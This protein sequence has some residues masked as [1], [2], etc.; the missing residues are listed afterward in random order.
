MKKAV[1]TVMMIT[2][3]SKALGFARDVVL[4]Y[5]FGA[6]N[7]T[8]AYFISLVIPGIIAGFIGAGITTAFIPMHSKI[9]SESGP[10]KGLKFTNNIIHLALALYT[11]LLIVGLLYTEQIVELFAYG[12]DEETSTL[13]VNLTRITLIGMYITGLIHVIRGYLQIHQRFNV[14]E[15][16][17]F[18]MNIITTLSFTAAYYSELLLLSVGRLVA[19]LGQL[20]FMLPSALRNGYS[21]HFVMDTKDPHVKRAALIAMPVILGTSIHQLNTLVDKTIASDLVVGGIAAL[22]YANRINELVQGTFVLSITIVMYPVLSKLFV[23]GNTQKAKTI[24]TNTLVGIS[25]LLIPTTVGTMLLAGPLVSLLFGRGAFDTTAEALTSSSLFYYAIGMI[26]F[27]FREVISRIFYS[28]QDT[29]T[30]MLNSAIG[31]V[32]NIILNII[33]S[34]YLGLGGLALAT[35]VSAIFTAI[36]MYYSLTQRIGSLDSLRIINSFL[37]I[38]F[39]SLI[40]GSSILLITPYVVSMISSA[41]SVILIIMSG[42]A[43]YLFVLYFMKIREFDEGVEFA[44]RKI[45]SLI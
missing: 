27:G 21:Y 25:I 40:M 31:I 32:L 5:Y 18:P 8:D 20:L 17:L 12:F 37:K 16:S 38:V 4:S 23:N 6:S 29:K 43:I 11:V 44:L 41:F 14:T 24:A 36:L 15:L 9:V 42:A 33:L 22:T 1:I 10:I 45:K 13:A 2:V 39:A 26:G 34:K 30:P 28:L 3:V 35:S 7:V 19:L